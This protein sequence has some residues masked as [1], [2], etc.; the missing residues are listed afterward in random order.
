MQGRKAEVVEGLRARISALENR[1]VL[2]NHPA[3]YRKGE[4]SG[5][6]D[7]APGLFHELFTPE[8]R[9]GGALLGFSLALAKSFLKPERP[10]V[11][12]VQLG[13]DTPDLGLPFGGGLSAFGFDPKTLILVRTAS[14]IEF[15]WAMEEA[16][17]CRHVAA[18]I[19]EVGRPPKQLDFTASRRF[20]LRAADAG[21]SAFILRYGRDREA[22]AATFRWEVL[23]EQS[24]E[25]PFDARAPGGPRWRVRL[26]KGLLGGS[27][28][29]K[30]WLLGWTEH[31]L[32]AFE[33]GEP[34]GTGADGT[35][36][37]HGAVPAALAHGLPQTA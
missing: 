26:E 20:S 22:S 33:H 8:A 7:T 3:A 4:A 24:S 17:A 15:L 11:L 14:I 34:A 18:V 5:L 36:P 9:N 21:T 28:G 29:Q 25:K 19:G 6:L 30:H 12:F 23:P 35:P 2:A 16:I 32:V 31:G 27:F 37:S 10:A 13:K 1:P